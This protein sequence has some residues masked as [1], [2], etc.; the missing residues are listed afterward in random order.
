[1][2]R[3]YG[4]DIIMGAIWTGFKALSLG[5]KFALIGGIMAFLLALSGGIY[6]AG[7]TKG[8][9]N[10]KIAVA[11]YEKKSAELSAKIKAVHN[12][13]DTKTVTKYLK[14]EVIA[15]ATVVKN[16]YIIKEHVPEQFKFSN[17][18]VYAY[19]QSVNGL[20]IDSVKASDDT[21]SWISDRTGLDYIHQ[22][23][24]LANS[25]A[26]Q[27]DSLIENIKEREAAT[28]ATLNQK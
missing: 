10:S 23:N 24:G 15:G 6:F 26:K 21:P 25:N 12:T 16:H 17:G 5:M 18:W 11:N 20:D 3:S 19:N 14:G 1:M 4:A 9:N 8:N 7:Y 27:L 22:N 13:V 28:D 2:E